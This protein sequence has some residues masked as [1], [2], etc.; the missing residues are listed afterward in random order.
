[1]RALYPAMADYIL[2]SAAQRLFIEVDHILGHK[3]YHNKFRRKQVIHSREDIQKKKDNVTTN[4]TDIT[5]II[6][7]TINNF[8]LINPIT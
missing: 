7:N 2:F 4:S 1:M 3:A 8:M 6:E 5:R